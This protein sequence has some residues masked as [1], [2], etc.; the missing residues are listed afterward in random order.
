MKLSDLSEA[1]YPGNIGVMEMVKFYQI[2]T[3]NQK[4]K[5]RD[6]LDNKKHLEAWKFLQKVVKVK[7]H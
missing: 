7:L 3:D 5:M 6:L 1:S 4:A 2:A